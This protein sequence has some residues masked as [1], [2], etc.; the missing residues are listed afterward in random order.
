MTELSCCSHLDVGAH[1]Y[2]G[3]SRLRT[4]NR[5]RRIQPMRC[6]A[7]RAST[8]RAFMSDLSRRLPKCKRETLSLAA[9]LVAIAI[10]S[11]AFWINQP[12]HL[13]NGGASSST[14]AIQAPVNR[15][16]PSLTHGL[17]SLELLSA[18]QRDAQR[19]TPHRG[20][21]ARTL[22]ERT[23]SVT[24]LPAARHVRSDSACGSRAAA[25]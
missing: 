2:D 6:V 17:L 12:A 3:C 10:G 4:G 19:L 15:K 14:A 21:S 9:S 23:P 25:R 1:L 22:C 13:F 7:I 8:V 24:A 20:T 5:M 16:S 18:M 11:L